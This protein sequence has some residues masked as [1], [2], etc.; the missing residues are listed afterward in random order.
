[1]DLSVFLQTLAGLSLG[2]KF[3]RFLPLFLLRHIMIAIPLA[4]DLILLLQR[5]LAPLLVREV[6]SHLLKED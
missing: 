4:G 6:Q 1:M 2:T 3:T 5:N